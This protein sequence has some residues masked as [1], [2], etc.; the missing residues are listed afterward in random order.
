MLAH[1]IE[2]ETPGF[3]LGVPACSAQRPQVVVAIDEHGAIEIRG[4]LD[5]RRADERVQRERRRAVAA[6]ELVDERANSCGF[7]RRR[8]GFFGGN[9]TTDGTVG[10]PGVFPGAVAGVVRFEVLSDRGSM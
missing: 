10:L 5:I 1:L 3:S 8:H 7:G 9:G 2:A 4:A 6:R